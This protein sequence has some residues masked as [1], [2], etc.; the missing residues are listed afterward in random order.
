MDDDLKSD[1]QIELG[2]FVH[3]AFPH[4]GIILLRGSSPPTSSASGLDLLLWGRKP[5]TRRS[6]RSWSPHSPDDWTG[7]RRPTF[8]A[9]P[10][11]V[12]NTPPLMDPGTRAGPPAA[13]TIR[14]GT[15]ADRSTCS[16]TLPVI[17][18]DSSQRSWSKGDQ[19]DLLLEGVIEDSAAVPRTLSAW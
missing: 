18:R 17:Q 15:P 5:L 14:S 12:D 1:D 3:D 16:A 13:R 4:T 11:C 8:R 7:T 9:S 10:W 19:I 2:T 6:S